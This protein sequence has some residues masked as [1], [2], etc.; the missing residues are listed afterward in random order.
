MRLRI[1]KSDSILLTYTFT[2]ENVRCMII[3]FSLVQEINCSLALRPVRLYS[4]LQSHRCRVQELD[5][6]TSR[7]DQIGE[8][9]IIACISYE[10]VNTHHLTRCHQPINSSTYALSVLKGRSLSPSAS[11]RQARVQSTT[12]LIIVFFLLY[13][14]LQQYQRKEYNFKLQIFINGYE[15]GNNCLRRLD[16]IKCFNLFK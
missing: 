16:R 1:R 8:T 10:D 3:A 11:C 13:H 5:I 15:I 6:E 12:A 4:P 2:K 14:Q 9:H 7:H